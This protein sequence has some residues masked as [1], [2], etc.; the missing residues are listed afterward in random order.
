M[1]FPWQIPIQ[2]PILLVTTLYQAIATWRENQTPPPG[3]RIDVGGYCLHLCTAGTSQPGQPIIVLD[4]SLG[5]VEG[6]LLIDQFATLGQVVVYDRAGYGWSDRSPHNRTSQTIVAELDNLLTQA[7]IAP[8]YLLVGDSF[9]SYNVRLYAHRFPEKVAGIV[10]TDGLHESGMLKM[11]L[12]LRALQLFFVSG[13]MMS[14]VGSGLGIVR[15]LRAIGLFGL[16]KPELRHYPQYRVA[17]TT[18]SF[19]RPK[20]W[21]T[22]SQEMLSLDASG[23]QLRVTQ[24][25]G[26][27]AIVSIK[28]A[29]FFKPSLWTK[30]IP[31]GAAN[32]LRDHMHEQLL[33]LSTN[34]TQLHAPDS[35][36]FVWLDQPAVILE[37]VKM[38]LAKSSQ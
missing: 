11:S 1:S 27:L 3:K 4:H 7:G 30:V 34:C 31:L 9:G 10:L 36:H 37:A 19:C 24:D 15:S 26:D 18:R 14:V 32:R 6:Y 38:I 22:M 5:G 23:R 35:G 12:I 28:A 13:F 20:H 2:I 8:P 25:L 29:S 33:T 16:L 17:A 21:F